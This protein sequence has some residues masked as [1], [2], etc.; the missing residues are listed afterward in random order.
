[1]DLQFVRS[2]GAVAGYLA[3][4][5]QTPTCI[6][7]GFRVLRASRGLLPPAR[8]ISVGPALDIEGY[9]HPRLS[10][11]DIKCVF[12]QASWRKGSAPETASSLPPMPAPALSNVPPS[13]PTTFPAPS[14]PPWLFQPAPLQAPIASPGFTFDSSPALLAMTPLGPSLPATSPL[15]PPLTD[16]PESEKSTRAGYREGLA[17]KPRS[18]LLWVLSP[19]PKN[20]ESHHPREEDFV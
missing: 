9:R 12:L 15:V 17:R 3:K 16:M 14:S 11:L 13:A 20:C 10:L 5:S 19:R 1:M 7:R 8:K 2:A 4:K 18:S 6:P